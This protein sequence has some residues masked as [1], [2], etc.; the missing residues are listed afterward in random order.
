MKI[1]IVGAFIVGLFINISNS[2][3]LG[4][5]IG[6]KVGGTQISISSVGTVAQSF[7]ST[8]TTISKISVWIS[9]STSI[10]LQLQ[11]SFGNLHR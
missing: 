3:Q 7:V 9:A 11:D 10:T 2:Q 4:V 5:S 1:C 6:S 8:T